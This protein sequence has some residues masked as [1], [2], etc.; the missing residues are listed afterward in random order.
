MKFKLLVLVFLSALLFNCTIEIEDDEKLIEHL[1]GK[2]ELVSITYDGVQKITPCDRT[3]VSEF[4][5]AS[6]YSGNYKGTVYFWTEALESCNPETF[7][8]TWKSDDG[9][10]DL[11]LTINGTN[12][13]YTNNFRVRYRYS[14]EGEDDDVDNSDELINIELIFNNEDEEFERRYTYRR[15][16]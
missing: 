5:P 10:F 16:I 9:D 11:T 8:G 6:A 3:T 12:T 1:A 13:S 4:I 14:S 15:I 2:W 7:R